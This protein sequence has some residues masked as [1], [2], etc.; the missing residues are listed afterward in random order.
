MNYIT[1]ERLM[2]LKAKVDAEMKRRSGYGS[3]A[4]VVIPYSKTPK[5]GGSVAVKVPVHPGAEVDVLGVVKVLVLVP[6][7]LGALPHAVNSAMRA[8]DTDVT[9]SVMVV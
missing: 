8:V 2:E 5:S 4:G 3:M 9:R 7:V 6:V 1:A